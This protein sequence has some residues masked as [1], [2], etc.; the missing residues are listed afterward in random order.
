M[1]AVSIAQSNT[2]Q[3]SP[4]QYAIAQQM[5]VQNMMHQMYLQYMNQ[6]AASMQQSN[7]VSS[8]ANYFPRARMTHFGVNSSNT[9][10]NERPPQQEA[11][12]A[13]QPLRF[14]AAIDDDAENRDWL[15][16]LYTMSRLLVLLSLVYFYSSP[17]RCMI[18]ILAFAL[19]Y[20]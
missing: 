13:P 15:E 3:Y 4:E 17:G 7:Q 18:V 5:A 14:Q 9:I 8:S 2:N 19:Y 16:I 12:P 10:I 1:P 20:L 11:E 6:Y